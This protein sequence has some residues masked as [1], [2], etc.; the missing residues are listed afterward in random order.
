MTKLSRDEFS[1]LILQNQVSMYRLAMSI[2]KNTADAEDTVSEAILIAYEHLSSLKKTDSFKAWILMI[3]ANEAKRVL[4][5][6]EKISLYDKV[7]LLN[8]P[9]KEDKTEIWDPVLALREEYSK[10]VILYYYEGF[11]T[12][13]IARI[14]RIP[15]GTVK[16]RL[17]RARNELRQM[18]ETR[19][20]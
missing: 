13:E 5:K 7:E 1:E 2:L 9:S 8:K 10:V 17:S 20:I 6:R 12:K 4:K 3:V 14:L 18:L 19:S 16:S 15:E 11:A